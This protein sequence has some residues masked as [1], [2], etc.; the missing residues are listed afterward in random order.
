MHWFITFGLLVPQALP[1]AAALPVALPPGMPSL[2]RLL[3][4]RNRREHFY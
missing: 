1:F 2:E 3:A 4:Q